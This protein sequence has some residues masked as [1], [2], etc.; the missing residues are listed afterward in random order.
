VRRFGRYVP[1]GSI[2]KARV[3][4]ERS[5]TRV[6][7]WPRGMVF[8]KR[9]IENQNETKDQKARNIEDATLGREREV[10]VYA[11]RGSIP[12]KSTE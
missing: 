11:V 12:F 6:S 3:P 5:G 8:N 10:S 4:N 9:E 7:K 2:G 1:R